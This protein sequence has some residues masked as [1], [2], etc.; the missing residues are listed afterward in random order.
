MAGECGGEHVA[1]ATGLRVALFARRG[2]ALGA[3]R[4]VVDAGWVEAGG[5]AGRRREW[6]AKPPH[7]KC[8]GAK[9]GPGPEPVQRDRGHCAVSRYMCSVEKMFQEPCS[10]RQ[11]WLCGDCPHARYPHATGPMHAATLL[12]RPGGCAPIAAHNRAKRRV[13]LDGDQLG[14]RGQNRGSK[15]LIIRTF[16]G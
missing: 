16:Q 4:L 2:A 9:G 6:P 15:H 12:E 8:D 11:Q 13:S 1:T 7:H 5:C 3:G 10:S 14:C